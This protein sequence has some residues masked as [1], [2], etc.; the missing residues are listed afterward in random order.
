LLVRHFT[1]KNPTT[2][3]GSSFLPPLFSTGSVL[4][5]LP[6]AFPRIL[7][8]FN[9]SHRSLP[10][11]KTT[12]KMKFLSVLA[13]TGLVAAEA[14]IYQRQV[15][16]L[17][18]VVNQV[19]DATAALDTAVKAFNGPSDIAGLQAAS[20][21]VGTTV[22]SGIDTVKGATTISL[23]DA[24]QIQ[25]QVQNLQ[26]TVE[27]VVNDLIAKKQTI[28]SAGAGQQVK[29]TL[30]DQLTGAKALSAA[31]SSKVPPEVQTL[32]QTL[33]AGI[34]SALQ[35]GVDAFQDAPAGGPSS[36]SG[37]SSAGSSAAPSSAAA[38]PTSAKPTKTGSSSSPVVT[39]SSPKP[40]TFSGA[41]SP[42]SVAGGFVA[43]A[44]V[45]AF[46]L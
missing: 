25:G 17:I 12:V 20:D 42:R 29:T 45:A 33:S 4:L 16:T 24:V 35:K 14:S 2:N 41:A 30:T 23:T 3:S 39:S 44:A 13:M 10:I 38:A 31:I 18:G 1:I 5:L 27:S 26:T 40:A 21:K 32:A 36:S 43:V 6:V 15:Q 8:L 7:Q 11:S 28:Y 46:A 9:I 19:G 37:G 34:A 22:S